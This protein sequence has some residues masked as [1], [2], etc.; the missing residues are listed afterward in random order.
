MITIDCDSMF[1]YFI[2][3]L[4]PLIWI[5]DK[6]SYWVFIINAN[7]PLVWFTFLDWIR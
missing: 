3:T 4:I 6:G 7:F 2:G 1:G 5:K